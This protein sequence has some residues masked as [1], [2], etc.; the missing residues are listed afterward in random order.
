MHASA[1]DPADSLIEERDAARILQQVLKQERV[2]LVN[3]DVEGLSGLTE[4][5]TAVAAQMSELA[6]RRHRLLAAAGFEATESG[7][8]AW[9]NS[10]AAGA[11]AVKSWNELLDLAQSVKELNRVNGLLIAQQMGRNQA[12]LNILQQGNAQGG[13]F[14]GPNGQS[15]TKIGSRRLV[16][17]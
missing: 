7:M 6:K 8:Q 13:S 15:S 14:Y 2:H 12:A 17:G 11:A 9:L 16:V 4:K 1:T 5:K 3:A 10:P